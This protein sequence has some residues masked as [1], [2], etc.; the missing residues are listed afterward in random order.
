METTSRQSAKRKSDRWKKLENLI[1]VDKIQLRRIM[2]DKSSFNRQINE[3]Y[4]SNS[5][6]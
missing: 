3:R 6:C 5:R 1:N 2:M 4:P